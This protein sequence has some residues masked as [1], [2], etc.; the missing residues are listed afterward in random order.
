MRI[1]ST[2]QC[3][4]AAIRHF[5][6]AMLCNATQRGAVMRRV[7]E[8]VLKEFADFIRIQLPFMFTGLCFHRLVAQVRD[9]VRLGHT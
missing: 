5:L 2:K 1:E 8:V 7:A 6:A 3:I 4:V 9:T